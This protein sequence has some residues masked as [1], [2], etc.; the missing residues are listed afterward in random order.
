MREQVMFSRR[1]CPRFPR[2][3]RI[4]RGRTG[5]DPSKADRAAAQAPDNGGD[6]TRDP[7]TP[8]PNGERRRLL[9]TAGAVGTGAVFGGHAPAILAQSK[10]PLKIGVLNSFSKV[11]AALG[12]A[13][14]N[15]MN[16]Y[17]DQ[18]GNTI[19]GRKIELIR[20]DDEI[21]PQVGLTKM[22]KL[23]ESDRVDL[24]TGV[25][26]SNVALALVDYVRQT[27]AFFL[28]SGAGAGSLSYVNVPTFFRA[29]LNSWQTLQ[30]FAGWMLKN[31]VKEVVTATSDFAGGRETVDDFRRGFVPAGGRIIKEIY[32]PLGTN[33]F[34]AYLADLRSIAPPASFSFFAGSDAVR[35]IKQY[36]EYGLRNR[37]KLYGS[38]FM[39]ESDV[40]PSQ[41]KDALGV[42]TALHYADTLDNPENRKF[43]ADFRARF[44]EFPSVYAEYGYVAARCIHESLTAIDGNT[45]DKDRMRGSMLA[46]RFNAPRGPFRFNPATQSPIHNVYVREVAEVDGRIANKVIDTI[47]D[48]REPDTRPA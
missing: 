6:M 9:V 28:C 32:A 10:A 47:R 33:D 31:A 12:Q 44:K 43:V 23:V 8:A 5:S 27:R 36:A 26:A 40:L 14:L 7:H 48:V 4:D 30:P 21:N 38:G 3:L 34:S 16:L 29:S 13:N 25:Q 20:E 24:V 39:V 41:G 1:D 15:G 46:M 35:Y 37:V 18:I 19:A 22:K 2:P 45:Q 11:F 17:F 42:V